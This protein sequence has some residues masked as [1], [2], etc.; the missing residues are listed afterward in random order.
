LDLASDDGEVELT[1]E[2]PFEPSVITWPA[3]VTADPPTE[4]VWPCSTTTPDFP[5]TG[6]AVWVVPSMTSN[7]SAKLVADANEAEAVDL[8]TDTP[9]NPF[10]IT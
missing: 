10:V 2:I 8:M 1:T 7:V 4:R 5:E 9:F 3:T 6:V